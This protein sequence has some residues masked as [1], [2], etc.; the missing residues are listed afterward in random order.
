M[1]VLKFYN[2]KKRDGGYVLKS[3]LKAK[4]SWIDSLN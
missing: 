1:N 4:E 2:K 3:N